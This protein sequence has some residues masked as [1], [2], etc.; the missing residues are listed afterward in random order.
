MAES[1]ANR[2]VYGTGCPDCAV[3]QVDLPQVL[4]QIGD[5]FDWDL[6]DHDSF[7]QFMLEALAARFPQRRRWT[8]A[9][10]EVALVEVLA[11]PAVVQRV[12]SMGQTV[13]AGKVDPDKAIATELAT[14]RKLVAE[15][16]LS[17]EL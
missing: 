1:P 3:H 5:D 4:P 9:D 17:I 8:S 12:E 7:R 16:K 6:R 15:R 13:A 14:W 10:V 11:S 2:I